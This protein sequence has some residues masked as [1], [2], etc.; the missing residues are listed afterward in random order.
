[1]D[2]KFIDLYETLSSLEESK[3]DTQRLIDFAGED[4]AKRFEEIKQ[5][6]K[7]PE[8]DLYY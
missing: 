6:L 7:A 5:R 3:A 4:L 2:I 1:M 8:N